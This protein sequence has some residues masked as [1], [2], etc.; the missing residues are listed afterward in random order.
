[1]LLRYKYANFVENHWFKKKQYE[2]IICPLL[3]FSFLS[4]KLEYNIHIS[5]IW[6]GDVLKLKDALKP[7][8]H[9]LD[10][11]SAT[12]MMKSFPYILLSHL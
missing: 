11:M 1:M 2:K 6:E 12:Q 9:R 5:S 10:L 4:S 8:T 7:V 3:K